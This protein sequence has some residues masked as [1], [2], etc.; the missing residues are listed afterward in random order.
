METARER[1]LCDFPYPIA[2]CYSLAFAAA[3]SPAERRWALCFTVYQVLRTICLT[4]ISQYLRESIDEEEHASI[5]ALN[6]AISGIR[7]PHFSDWIALI[8]NLRRH[9]DKVGIKSCFPELAKALD[10]LKT[11]EE[12]TVGLQGNHQL[13]ALRAILALRNE[14]AHG[15]IPNQEEAERHLAVYMPVLHQILEAFD[16]LGDCRLKICCDPEGNPRTEKVSVRDLRGAEPGPP[17][18]VTVPAEL[19]EAFTESN[20]VLLRPPAMSVPL[21]PLFHPVSDGEPLFLYDGHYSTRLKTQQGPVERSYIYYLGIHHR[22]TDGPSCDRLKALLARRQISFF[23][24]KAAA[25]PWTIADSAADH[26]RRTLA[27]LLG[28]KYF[29]EC[30]LPFDELERHFDSFLRVPD[31]STWSGDT[32]QRRYVNG[33][34]LIG[35]AGAGKTAFLASQ[36]ERLLAPAIEEAGDRDNPNLVMFFRGNGIA[37]RP[38]G[39]SLFRDVTEKLGLAVEGAGIK[40][41]GHG[42]FS[43]FRE[44]LDHLH[45]CWQRDNIP[46]RRLILILDAVNEAIFAQ[47]IVE[48]ALEMVGVAACYPWCKMVVSTRQEWLAL[49]SGKM[50]AQETSVLSELRANL[51]TLD[52]AGRESDSAPEGSSAGRAERSRSQGPPVITM[53]P[54]NETQAGQIYERYRASA[55]AGSGVNTYAIPAC[56]T[57]WTELAEPTRALLSNPLHVHLFMESFNGRPA[58]GV[59]AVPAIF[60]RYVERCLEERPALRA[61]V[62][63]VLE[64]LLQHPDRLSADLT[65]DDANAIRRRWAD[66]LSAEEARLSLSPLEGLTHEGFVTK[67]VRD[68]GGG[69]RFVFQQVAEYLIYRHFQEQRP[70]GQDEDAYWL[71][72]A[73]PATVFAEYGGAFGFLFR[74][75]SATAQVEKAGPLVEAGGSWLWEVLVVFLLD[76]ALQGYEQRR[77]NREAE[78]AAVAL[79]KAGGERSAAALL[80]AGRQ[81]M[82]QPLAGAAAAYLDSGS[83]RLE[84]MLAADPGKATIAKTLARGLIDRGTMAGRLGRTH[85]AVAAYRLSITT[86]ER[87]GG[88]APRD[89]EIAQLLGTALDRLGATLAVSDTADAKEEGRKACARSVKICQMLWYAHP[90]DLEIANAYGTALLSETSVLVDSNQQRDAMVPCRM[91]IHLYKAL[92]EKRPGN[93]V[94]GEGYSKALY[95]LAVLRALG[96]RRRQ[97]YDAIRRSVDIAQMLWTANPG[98]VVLGRW[99]ARS[100]RWLASFLDTWG[101]NPDSRRMQERAADIEIFIWEVSPENVEN[102]V[103]L[104][105]TLLSLGREEDAQARAEQCPRARP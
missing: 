64:H 34:L 91:A 15:G 90:Y 87:A 104:C 52:V 59:T 25:A 46:R 37:L 51:Y 81:L 43:N 103:Q 35:R 12:R 26:S 1:V 31:Q 68:E 32:S 39:V 5:L 6:R 17:I 80:E 50:G 97:A 74:D 56:L 57:P 84:V 38:E 14:I 42:G 70:A 86:C 24:E 65:D 79:A 89:A 19:R 27:E 63:A 28:T 58:Q 53:E 71:R 55:R 99:Y 3:N 44:L 76:R 82:D 78:V 73:A 47:K 77:R 29:P 66:A 98:N 41:R 22:A 33:L 23:L 93:L 85:D 16:F 48:E 45:R 20:A 54:L 40:E 94:I 30:Y 21:Y 18:L 101:R 95:N 10:S 4:L 9:L 62:T 100:L 75:W 92:W 60:R 88:T 72:R 61:S 105:R 8:E 67:R 102:A 11:P 96:Q 49:W 2:C 13:A 36:V 69:Y 83:S 7:S